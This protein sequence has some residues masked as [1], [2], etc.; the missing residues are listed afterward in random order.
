MAEDYYVR[1]QALYNLALFLPD[2]MELAEYVPNQQDAAG[3]AFD[4]L[5]SIQARAV[6]ISFDSEHRR[7]LFKPLYYLCLPDVAGVDNA[8]NTT[9]QGRNG[10]VKFAMRV[11][12]D[13]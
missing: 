12:D 3:E 6:I 11:G 4:S 8:I 9:K 7:D 13:S 5:G 2:L 1:R 10:R